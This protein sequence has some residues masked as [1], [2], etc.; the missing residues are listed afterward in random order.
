[1][2]IWFSLDWRIDAPDW[3]GKA[4]GLAYNPSA[5]YEWNPTD[6]VSEERIREDMKELARIAT[7]V[8]T[9]SVS[10]GLDKVVPI[11]AEFGMK[12]T[13]GAWLSADRVHNREECDRLIALVLKYPKLID[14]VFVGNEANFRNELSGHEVANY[15][16][17]VKARIPKNV[18]VSTA[19]TYA[20]WLRPDNSEM[21]ETADFIG[22]HL[23]PFWEGVPAEEAL[24]QVKS[25]VQ[26]LRKTF[27]GKTVVIAEVGWPSAGRRFKESIADGPSAAAFLRRFFV[28]AKTQKWDY[29][30]MEAYDQPWKV[31]LEGGVGAFWGIYDA[32]GNPKFDFK[33]TLSSLPEWPWIAGMAILLSVL[34]G[35]ALLRTTPHLLFAGLLFLASSIAA[36][37]SGVLAIFW[38]AALQYATAE[39][40]LPFAGIVL[41]GSLAGAVMITEGIEMAHA[42]WRSRRRPLVVANN[43]VKPFISIHVPC[44]NE[45]ADMMCETLDALA[46]LD[47]PNFEV[48]VLDNNTKD[49][50]VWRPVEAHCKTLGS[51]FRFFHFEGVKGFKAGALNIALQLTDPKAEIVAVIDSDYQVEPNWLTDAACYFDDHKVGLVQAPQ[52]YRDSSESLFKRMTYE[53]YAGFFRIGMVERHEDNAIIQHGTMTMMRKQALIDVGAWSEWCITEDTELGLR[54]F[55]AGWH[56]VYIDRSLGRGVMPDTLGAYK[57]QRHRWVYGA[58]QIMKRHLGA[59]MG[60]STQ[61]SRAQKYHFVSGWLPW[62]ADALA[63]FFTVGGVVWSALMIYDPF[64][65]EVPLPALTAVAISL[66]AVKVVKTLSLYP[67]RV[68]TG[69][70]GAIAASVAGLALSHTVARA[71]ISGLLTSGKPFFRTPKMEATAPVRSVLAVAW[72]E[73][74]LLL[75]LIAAIVGTSQLRGGWEDVA[76][77]T[78]MVMLA[79]QALPYTATLVMAIISVLPHTMPAPKVTSTVEPDAEPAYAKAA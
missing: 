54:L 43:A 71:V 30:I 59:L 53:E 17:Y 6:R 55:E 62:I 34:A 69:F 23:L 74:V 72:E 51:R 36:I 16:R 8:R 66:F 5:L 20:G 42:L 7:R 46:K 52:D 32:E 64:R 2:A 76:G 79:I 75:A 11:A 26:T 33:G 45:P 24:D 60:K 29:Y 77:L 68:K 27:A 73:I 14:R 28:D 41:I 31:A 13:P 22:A 10:R 70:S 18:L 39:Q 63:F 78:W 65:F 58:M 1:L 48:I 4:R 12:V 61:L 3:N 37:A 47:Y 40:L 49:E 9:Y 19:E 15:M 25:Q 56:S 67:H 35:G 21:G 50:A 44:Y 38:G 57:V